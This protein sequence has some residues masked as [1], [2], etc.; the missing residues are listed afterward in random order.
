MRKETVNILMIHEL[1][2]EARQ[3]AYEDHLSDGVLY[4]F[5]DEN[6]ESLE[7]FEAIFPITI[8]DWSYDSCSGYIQF[9]MYAPLSEIED[10]SGLR[11]SR[12]LYNNYWDQITEGK[13]YG[14]LVNTFKDGHPIPVSSQHPAGVRH[15][16]RYSKWLR[17]SCCPF[18]GYYMD[19]MLLTPLFK[20]MNRP[21]DTTF[22]ELMEQCLDAWVDACIKDRQDQESFEHFVSTAEANDW[23]F[24]ENGERWA[25]MRIATLFPSKSPN[26]RL[27]A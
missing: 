1:S 20:F 16:K 25:T 6:K 22:K 14:K 23:E 27:T 13:Y 19:D 18:T 24:T 3:S 21:D 26:Q 8:N 17:E 11:L 12:Y 9:E 7:A 4:A 15:V 2:E 5:E 10:M